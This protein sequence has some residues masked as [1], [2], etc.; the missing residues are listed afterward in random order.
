MKHEQVGIDPETGAPL[1]RVD[2]TDIIIKGKRML[3][4]LENY[5]PINI[6]EVKKR[7]DD[8]VNIPNC[9]WDDIELDL[10]V[11]N[12][13]DLPY[14]L[15]LTKLNGLPWVLVQILNLMKNDV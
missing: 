1:L 11:I 4:E 5:V 12:N 14:T 7:W 6:P 2:D 8:I 9:L 10:R 15:R 3:L 13:D